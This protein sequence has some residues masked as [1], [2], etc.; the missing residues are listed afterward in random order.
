M[1]IL[2][3]REGARVF[4]IWLQDVLSSNYVTTTNFVTSAV[5]KQLNNLLITNQ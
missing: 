2:N 4:S 1:S 5:T 3:T